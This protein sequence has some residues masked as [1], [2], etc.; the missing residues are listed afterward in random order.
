[1]LIFT[2]CLC[3]TELLLGEGRKKEVSERFFV[4]RSSFWAFVGKS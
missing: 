1:M 2:N 3:K 4:K